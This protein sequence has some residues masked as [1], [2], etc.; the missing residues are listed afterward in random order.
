MYG[1]P[2]L[3]ILHL[4]V[5]GVAKSLMQEALQMK[6]FVMVHGQVTTCVIDQI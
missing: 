4:Q 3:A 5:E 1:E 6:V 2:Y